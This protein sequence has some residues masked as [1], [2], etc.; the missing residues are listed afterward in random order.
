MVDV[1]EGWERGVRGYGRGV[2][3]EYEGDSSV[4][5]M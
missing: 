5:E 1:V 4:N 2:G 3:E